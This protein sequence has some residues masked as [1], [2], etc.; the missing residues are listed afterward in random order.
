MQ[1]AILYTIGP[2]TMLLAQYLAT[3]QEW[4]IDQIQQVTSQRGIIVGRHDTP[5]EFE[6]IGINIE[7]TRIQSIEVP[8]EQEAPE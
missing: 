8:D 5:L 7:G 2:A 3:Q 6:G 1:T 4:K